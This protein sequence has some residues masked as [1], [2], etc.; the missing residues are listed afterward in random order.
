MKD[1]IMVEVTVKQLA[2]VVGIPVDK[3]LTQMCD[4]GLPHKNPDD[5]PCR[6]Q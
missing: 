4:A 6:H 1:A 5:A 3:L 2:D